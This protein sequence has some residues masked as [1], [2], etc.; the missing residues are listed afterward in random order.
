MAWL[1]R[2]RLRIRFGERGGRQTVE[3]L[4]DLPQAHEA[5]LRRLLGSFRL[6]RGQVVVRTDASGRT[7]VSFD[8]VPE[9]YHQPIRNLIGNLAR[10]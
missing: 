5:K 7:R 1:S 9:R 4:G 3:V 8:G 2:G 10:L 6:R